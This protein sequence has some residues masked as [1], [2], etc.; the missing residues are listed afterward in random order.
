MVCGD[1]Q[2][3]VSLVEEAGWVGSDVSDAISSE[4]GILQG[5]KANH[6]KSLCLQTAGKEKNRECRL[7]EEIS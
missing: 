2:G 4:G 7:N 1:C 5:G 6:L 3:V